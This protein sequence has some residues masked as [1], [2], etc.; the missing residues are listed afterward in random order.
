[1]KVKPSCLELEAYLNAGKSLTEISGLTGYSVPYISELCKN[2]CGLEVPSIGRPKGYKM[3]D[4]VKQ[5][6][7]EAN[8]K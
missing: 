3:P 6:I 8:R 1:M 4:E 7:S 5:K 2:T